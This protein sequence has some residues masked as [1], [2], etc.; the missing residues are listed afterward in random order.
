MKLLER[1]P[2]SDDVKKNVRFSLFSAMTEAPSPT[3]NSA[4]CLMFLTEIFFP[5][6]EKVMDGN[7]ICR[8]IRR[9]STR[10]AMSCPAKESHSKIGNSGVKVT[11]VP[12]PDFFVSFVLTSDAPSLHMIV[13]HAP[14]DQVVPVNTLDRKFTAALPRPF[15]PIVVR[16]SSNDVPAFTRVHAATG[17]EIVS[18]SGV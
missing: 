5:L 12:L 16:L 7:A 17:R 14:L 1:K 13:R 11:D 8:P 2:S 10:S 15:A 3:N 6:N 9:S 4:Y 18:P